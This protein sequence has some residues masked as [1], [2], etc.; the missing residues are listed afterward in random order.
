MC[1]KPQAPRENPLLMVFRQYRLFLLGPTFHDD[2]R[3]QT[4]DFDLP[5]G[6]F[7]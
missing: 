7:K 5:N 4:G 1:E 2:K 6:V 3:R